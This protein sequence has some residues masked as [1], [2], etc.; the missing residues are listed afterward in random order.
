M[1]INKFDFQQPIEIAPNKIRFGHGE[2]IW[3]FYSEVNSDEQLDDIRMITYFLITHFYFKI[4]NKQKISKRN[5][6]GRERS[7]NFHHVVFTIA[8]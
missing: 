4:E 7:G 5:I 6:C 8:S 3:D 1:I 2:S